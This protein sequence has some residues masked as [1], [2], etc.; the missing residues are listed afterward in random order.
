L[1]SDLKQIEDRRLFYE[2]MIKLI[3]LT[4]F[5]LVGAFASDKIENQV[6]FMPIDEN[7][8]QKFNNAAE[9]GDEE[10]VKILLKNENEKII[11]Y[12]TRENV[13]NPFHYM[14]K[15]GN[16]KIVKLILNVFVGEVEK[17]KLIEYLMKE[18]NKK[19]TAL[20]VAT[21]KGHEKIVQLVLNVFVGV[22]E[23]DKLIEY[24]MKE[25]NKKNTVLHIASKHGHEKIVKLFL[26]AFSELN[27]KKKLIEFVRQEN[28]SYETALHLAT[29]YGN[30]KIIDSLLNVFCEGEKKKMIKFV[31][32]ENEYKET[33]LHIA[34]RIGQEEIEIL[35][36]N[37]FSEYGFENEKLIEYV[38]KENKYKNTV[39][40]LTSNTEIVEFILNIFSTE[41]QKQILIE[42]IMIENVDK[43]TALHT[44]AQRGDEGIVTLLLNVFKKL[45]AKQ[46]V[47]F[48]EK[49]KETALLFASVNRHEKKIEFLFNVFAK[50]EIEKL[51]QYVMDQNLNQTSETFESYEPSCWDISFPQQFHTIC[52][53]AEK[54]MN[55]AYNNQ[56]L[57]QLMF[58]SFGEKKK[59]K[60]MEY[61]LKENSYKKTILNLDEEIINL[62]NIFDKEK[63]KKLID[64]N[65]HNYTALYY[66]SLDGNVN[67]LKLLS[68][69]FG[70]EKIHHKY[71]ALHFSPSRRKKYEENSQNT[72]LFLNVFGENTAL[73]IAST[74]QQAEIAKLLVNIFGNDEKLIEYVMKENNN[75]ETA[76]HLASY[77]GN[78]KIV[79]LFLNVFGKDT[80]KKLI[81]YL[82]HQKKTSLH[83]ESQHEHG[84]I[85]KMILD[86]FDEDMKKK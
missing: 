24:L 1:T 37:L 53:E 15:K 20:Y 50:D 46:V 22:D 79:K 31:M 23:K 36:L 19:N 2:N 72:K 67:L 86:I 68:N 54:M 85:I 43:N 26:N 78:E 69:I 49:Q 39:L 70:R 29:S 45:N 47:K 81:Q 42:Y 56:N 25:N 65:T 14:A 59:H 57:V 55:S 58:N 44:A 33:A 18:N 21:K 73:H 64:E 8:L 66:F 60:L 84:K 40:H 48:M 80:E 6:K 30:K 71:K 77:T 10:S 35:L 63:R 83:S 61:V 12:L 41:D 9:K 11:E 27:E 28:K 5:I 75:N 16:E 3:W 51:M 52:G 4:I 32:K 34:S 74:H 76:L 62:L 38:M 7:W 17:K 13:S 82:T